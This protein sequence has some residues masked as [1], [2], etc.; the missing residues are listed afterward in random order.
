MYIYYIY[1]VQNRHTSMT[2][3][4]EEKK[5]NKLYFFVSSFYILL[6]LCISCQFISINKYYVYKYCMFS[7]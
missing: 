7:L 5:K 1:K 3:K 2:E 4:Y 6:L